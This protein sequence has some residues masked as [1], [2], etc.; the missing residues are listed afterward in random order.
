MTIK[1]FLN[2]FYLHDSLIENIKFTGSELTYDISLCWWMQNEYKP[3]DEE[4]R[5]IRLVFR[6]IK[7]FEFEGENKKI[8]SD[9]ILEFSIEE[10]ETNN[11]HPLIKV[12][13]GDGDDIKVIKFR[14]D[15]V[16]LFWQ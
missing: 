3:N 9:T 5:K 14:A 11:V 16:D 15:T 1:E 8:D 13:F 12:V 6:K 10:D 7:C 4:I 2:R